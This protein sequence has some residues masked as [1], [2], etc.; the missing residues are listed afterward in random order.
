VV[1]QWYCFNDEVVIPISEDDVLGKGNV[2]MLFYE[3]IERTSISR[4]S[5][6]GADQTS[7][8]ARMNMVG[9]GDIEGTEEARVTAD[10]GRENDILGSAH[11]GGR[12]EVL[13]QAVEDSRE[14]GGNGIPQSCVASEKALSAAP[15]GA[16]IDQSPSASRLGPLMRSSSASALLSRT[17][18]CESS[19][20]MPSSSIISAV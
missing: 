5:S 14:D 1:E 3:A 8:D 17:E 19:L 4:H 15:G 2:F 11:G 16:L 18:R 6:I 9:L 20:A 13:S 12:T 7:V 10:K